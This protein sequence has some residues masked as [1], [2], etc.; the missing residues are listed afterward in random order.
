MRTQFSSFFKSALVASL[1]LCAGVAGVSSSFASGGGS[2]GGGATSPARTLR[3][4]AR[5]RLAGT[6]TESKVRYELRGLV[7]KA[8]VE[9][10]RGVPNTTYNASHLG[11]VFATVTTDGLGN[12]KLEIYSETDN[13]G[14]PQDVPVMAVGDAVSVGT[15]NG[16]LQPR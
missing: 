9:V 1:V 12:A 14:G 13:P 11:N 3:L 7:R 4:E 2:G 6:Q 10:S 16:T 5:M 8:T 15:M